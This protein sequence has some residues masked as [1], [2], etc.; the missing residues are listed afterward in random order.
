MQAREVRSRW[1]RRRRA[2]EACGWVSSGENIPPQ[3][4]DASVQMHYTHR[5]KNEIAVHLKKTKV[6]GKS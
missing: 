6:S 4:V 2:A 3:F 1:L 5:I